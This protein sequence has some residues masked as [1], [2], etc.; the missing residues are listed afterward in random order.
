MILS[1]ELI[2][3]VPD[4]ELFSLLETLAHVIFDLGELGLVRDDSVGGGL[5]F[6]AAPVVKPEERVVRV[7]RVHYDLVQR[8]ARGSE[9]QI[10]A[11]LQVVQE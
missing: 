5:Q 10:E 11:Q 1:G 4:E 6:V 3:N 2:G 8:V 7:V 9:H